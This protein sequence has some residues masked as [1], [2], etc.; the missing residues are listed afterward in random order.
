MTTKLCGAQLRGD[1]DVIAG[2]GVT[3]NQK[4]THACRTWRGG[5]V[6]RCARHADVFAESVPLE[7]ISNDGGTETKTD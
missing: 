6:F 5:T 4:A 7:E 2:R 1:D 3:C